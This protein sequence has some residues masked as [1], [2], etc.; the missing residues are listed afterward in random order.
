MIDMIKAEREKILSAKPTRF[1]FIMGIVLIAA[2]F[3]LFQFGYQTVFYNYE[4]GEM[5]SESGF[6]AIARRRETAA[7][8]EGELTEKTLELMRRK[9]S[10]A[11]AMMIEQ[12]ED[13]AFS[14]VNVYRDQ[15]TMLEY[16]KNPDGSL[17]SIEDGYPGSRSIILGYCDGWDK[18]VSAMGGVLSLMMCVLIVITLSPVF[19][20]DRS[21]HTDGV[22]YAARYGKTKLASA[23]VIAALETVTGI[24]FI[25]LSF[26]FILYGSTYGLQ[27]WNVN[28]QSSL[29]FASSTY[30]LTFLQLFLYSALCNVL[31]AGA[32]SMI[33]LFISA[34]MNT[35]VSALIVSCGVCFWPVVFD[36]TDSLPLVQKVQE[37]WPVFM[38]HINGVFASVKTYLGVAQPTVMIIA[39]S[40]ALLIFYVLT[41]RVSRKRQVTG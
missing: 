3:F 40:G 38:L 22:I 15:T 17:K 8:F 34:K 1:L 12:D 30:D 7:L 11:E 32:L 35:P 19:A 10:D 18:M 2:D 27:G 21:C 14:A 37:L 16:L 24:Y 5:D 20:E 6:T 28:I 31:G 25:F 4:K 29:H 13:T 41:K 39:N 33:A 36:F 23:K 26:I 9:I